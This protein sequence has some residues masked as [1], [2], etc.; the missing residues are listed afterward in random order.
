MKKKELMHGSKELNTINN[1]DMYDTYKYLE[2]KL[3]EKL[4]LG[5]LPANGLKAQ[6]GAKKGR[7]YRNK[8]FHQRKCN[9][10]DFWLKVRNSFEF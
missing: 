3:E 5:I 4:L 10:T 2:E 8:S 1:T 6:V 9:E 7:W